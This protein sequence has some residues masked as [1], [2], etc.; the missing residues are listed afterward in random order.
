MLASMYGYK[1]SNFVQILV[2]SKMYNRY[3][4]RRRAIHSGL[5]SNFCLFVMIRNLLLFS[6]LAKLVYSLSRC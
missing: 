3:S 5:G 4:E 6:P 1:F 2:L